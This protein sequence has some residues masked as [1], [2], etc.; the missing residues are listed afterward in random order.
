MVLLGV[1]DANVV[2]ATTG[3]SLSSLTYSIAFP[4][5]IMDTKADVE[6][7]SCLAR[8]RCQNGKATTLEFAISLLVRGI[9]LVTW[10]LS[11]HPHSIS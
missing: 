11:E 8:L 4:T 5:N 1:F 2:F 6:I 10:K 9:T 3:S 7:F